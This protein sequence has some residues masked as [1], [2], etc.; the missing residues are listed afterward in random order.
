MSKTRG[1]PRKIKPKVQADVV[2]AIQTGATYEI[3][4]A[5]A[6]IS[7]GSFNRWMQLGRAEAERLMDAHAALREFTDSSAF[8]KLMRTY[9][10]K[11][12]S[13][14]TKAQKAK[15]RANAPKAPKELIE[16]SRVHASERDF[17]YFFKAVTEGN[18]V[19][20]MGWLNV[21]DTVAQQD[22][23]W[24]SWML[25]TRY[26][27]EYGGQRTADVSVA[28]NGAGGGETIIRIQYVDFQPPKNI[29]E[30]MTDGSDESKPT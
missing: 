18:A 28:T 15:I 26:P 13:A 12:L 1:R 21:I 29:E 20:A 7:Y 19:A 27:R 25:K 5:Y 4:S 17:L 30:E 11:R 8:Q 9:L 10:I 23:N 3:A 16:N 22:P 14:R 6:G 2:Q 24:A